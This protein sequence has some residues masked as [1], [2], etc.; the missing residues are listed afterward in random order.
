M[1]ISRNFLVVGVVYLLVG[2]ALGSVM[3]ATGVH[4]LLPV[5]A[6]INLLGFTLMAIFAALYKVFPAMAAS[7][8]ARYHFWLHQAGTLI[9][10]TGLYLMLSETVTASIIG[11]IMPV[12]ELLLIVGTAIFGWNALKNATSE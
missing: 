12:S 11:P 5:H 10:V 1:N 9:L 3:G 6:H 4:T 8:L 7:A 2:M